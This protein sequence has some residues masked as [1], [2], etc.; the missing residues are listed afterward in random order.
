MD[1]SPFDRG[2]TTSSGFVFNRSPSVADKALLWRGDT[3]P[4]LTGYDSTVFLQVSGIGR[5]INET[6]T[7]FT[8][9]NE[10][11]VFKSFRAAIIK[12]RTA[13]PNYK[14]PLPWTP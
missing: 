11:D 12:T 10:V 3:N 2:M 6:D 9:Q 4:T 5:W 8:P 13:K 1:Q 7:N 14:M